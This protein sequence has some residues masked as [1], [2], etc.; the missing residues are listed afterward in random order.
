MREALLIQC[1][2]TDFKAFKRIIYDDSYN[3]IKK[4]KKYFKEIILVCANIPENAFIKEFARK[5]NIDY[6]LGNLMDVSDRFYNCM[7]HFHIQFGARI[8]YILVFSR[9]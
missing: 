3:V 8:F 6:F 7:E 2:Y 5:N 1:H 9:F 4:A